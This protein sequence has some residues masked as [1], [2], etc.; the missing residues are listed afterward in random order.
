MLHCPGGSRESRNNQGRL[1]TKWE[2]LRE[3]ELQGDW[4][5]EPAIHGGGARR[6]R[7][8]YG[9]L[10][11]GI[12]EYGSWE[13]SM[14]SFRLVGRSRATLQT[15]REE[16]GFREASKG[17]LL[18]KREGEEQKLGTREAG[19]RGVGARQAVGQALLLSA[20]G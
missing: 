13:S 15:E 7:G 16:Q 5:G 4:S 19:R 10:Q 12:E 14:G 9:K 11:T 2:G 1:Q 3:A 18:T 17:M 8:R 20:G 6:Y